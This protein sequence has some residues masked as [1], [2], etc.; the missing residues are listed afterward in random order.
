MF[1]KFWVILTVYRQARRI[2]SQIDVGMF[3][4]TEIHRMSQM[5]EIS[6]VC[7]NVNVKKPFNHQNNRWKN[8][9]E[10]WPIWSGQQE[11][12]ICG[13]SAVAFSLTG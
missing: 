4:E 2:R 12:S 7:D 8:A 11:Q 10:I 5:E 9:V 13:I 3:S 6:V 1:A